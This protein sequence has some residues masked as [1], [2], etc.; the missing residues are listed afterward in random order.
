M[1]EEWTKADLAQNAEIEALKRRVA[2]LEARKVEVPKAPTDPR[3]D[4]LVVKVG[5][6]DPLL[7]LLEHVVQIKRF[8]GKGA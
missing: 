4:E 1:A 2:T 3:V 7:D 8:F 6:L 5:A